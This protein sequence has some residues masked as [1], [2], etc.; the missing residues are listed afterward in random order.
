MKRG[1]RGAWSA[2]YDWVERNIG[3]NVAGHRRAL[4]MTQEQLAEAIGLEVKSLQRIERGYGNVT[5]RVFVA[6]TDALSVHPNMLLTYCEI[7]PPK[8]GR[9]RK[10][11]IGEAL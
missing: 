3:G 2:K 5:A 6:L 7:L 10:V 11:R 1:T 4:G 9:P 8:R